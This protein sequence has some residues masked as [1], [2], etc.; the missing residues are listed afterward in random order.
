[1]LFIG[2]KFTVTE[3][4]WN[5]QK[6]KHYKDLQFS[7]WVSANRISTVKAVSDFFFYNN[8]YFTEYSLINK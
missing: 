3:F 7:G 1:M 8:L 5:F 2:G 6:M 4:F